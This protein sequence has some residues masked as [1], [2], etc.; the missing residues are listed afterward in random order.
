MPLEQ[1][2]FISSFQNVVSEPAATAL[3]GNLLEGQ[4][5]ISRPT[6]TEQNL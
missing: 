2:Y 1:D 5:L 6:P 4:I 3:P